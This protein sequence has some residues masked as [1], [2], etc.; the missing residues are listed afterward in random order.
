MTDRPTDQTD[1]H[2]AVFIW[3]N[4]NNSVNTHDI[5]MMMIKINRNYVIVNGIE[6]FL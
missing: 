6:T 4:S 1:G 3:N 2:E 5:M